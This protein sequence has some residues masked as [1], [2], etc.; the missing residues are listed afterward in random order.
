M[1]GAD[2]LEVISKLIPISKKASDIEEIVVTIKLKNG[3]IKKFSKG[4]A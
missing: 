1:T 3:L 4:G 2:I